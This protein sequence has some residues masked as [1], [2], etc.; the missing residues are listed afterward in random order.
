MLWGCNSISEMI[1]SSDIP[2]TGILV[3]DFSYTE[4]KFLEKLKIQ[5][6]SYSD[7]VISAILFSIQDE[8][9]GGAPC[10]YA[11]S[12]NIVYLLSDET[13]LGKE[14]F[15]TLKITNL[16]YLYK[17]DTI[18]GINVFFAEMVQLIGYPGGYKWNTLFISR[19]LFLF[20]FYF[21]FSFT[22]ICVRDC[23][24]QNT[25]GPLILALYVL[26][27]KF[28]SFTTTQAEIFPII[29]QF[30]AFKKSLIKKRYLNKKI[31]L[32]LVFEKKTI[33]EFYGSNIKIVLKQYAAISVLLI[34]TVLVGGV[35]YFGQNKTTTVAIQNPMTL[36]RKINPRFFAFLKEPVK[37][38]HRPQMMVYSTLPLDNEN[39]QKSST[40][41][42]SILSGSEDSI[43]ITTHSVFV[44]NRKRT[45]EY[46][47]VKAAGIYYFC[48]YVWA[49]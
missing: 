14:I 2:F 28:D 44:S 39:S 42:R 34:S 7:F 25:M 29:T 26:E 22:N 5:N 27:F 11:F 20:N 6:W 32:N 33:K 43:E 37:Y 21:T 49:L 30:Q 35:F 9:T 18:S 3:Q 8:L 17:Q 16:F 31:F 12:K 45:Y 40:P 47:I 19:I 23:V 41:I 13:I 48:P 10:F 15:E 24:K 1:F 38:R 46:L 36:Q 4:I